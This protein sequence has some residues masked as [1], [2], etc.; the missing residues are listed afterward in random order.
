MSGVGKS[1]RLV[2]GDW[3]ALC[4]E[5]GRKFKASQMIRHWQ[6]Y[7]VCQ[8]H[9][10][11]R[12][13]QD[14]VRSVPDVITP[15]WVQPVSDTFIRYIYSYPWAPGGGIY[16]GDATP[17]PN[18]VP[19]PDSTPE[20]PLGDPPP[21]PT[22]PATCNGTLTI[23]IPEGVTI[24][25]S[26]VGQSSFYFPLGWET[27]CEV[28]IINQGSVDK[29]PRI[30]PGIPVTIIGNPVPGFG[31]GSPFAFTTQDGLALT[32]SVRNRTGSAGTAFTNVSN[33]KV[34]AVSDVGVLLDTGDIYGYDGILR[35]TAPTIPYV[36]ADDRTSVGF[37]YYDGADGTQLFRITDTG[38]SSGSYSVDVSLE[39]YLADQSSAFRIGD[40][41]YYHFSIAG[42]E[43]LMAYNLLT[44]V[45]T[46]LLD[47]SAAYPTATYFVV[48]GNLNY[49]YVVIDSGTGVTA[50]YEHTLL[51]AATGRYVTIT[52][53]FSDGVVVHCM[54][55]DGDALMVSVEAALVTGA[56]IVSIDLAT[57]SYI[58]VTSAFDTAP[59]FTSSCNIA[60]APG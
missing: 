12:Q 51:G 46:A 26:E 7:Y 39:Q 29:P 17:A 1:D 56:L 23:T 54:T 52:T 35:G 53:P 10:E 8:Q 24:I 28:V 4:F 43:T 18:R 11:P 22:V 38:V 14:F 5:C 40:Y 31:S 6:G 33:G 55:C 48:C 15:P 3:N 41:F 45:G 34:L 57:M 37:I 60:K 19:D 58:N 16:T 21:P 49:L 50:V 32:I 13:S 27:L 36:A 20:I 44:G 9:W 25:P 59:Q 30:P 42:A 47:L 2:V